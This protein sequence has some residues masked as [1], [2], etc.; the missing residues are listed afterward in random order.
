MK[1]GDL[2]STGKHYIALGLIVKI[3]KNKE[4]AEVE[5]VNVNYLTRLQYICDLEVI[6]K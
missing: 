6:C 4:L 1:I 5:W 3:S 2:G